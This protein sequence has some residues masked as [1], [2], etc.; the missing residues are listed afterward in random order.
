MLNTPPSDPP[1]RQPRQSSLLGRWLGWTA[2]YAMLVYVGFRFTDGG[3]TGW[4]GE[5]RGLGL[6]LQFLVPAVAAFVIGARFRSW[7]WVLGPI[8]AI[9]LPFAVLMVGA[10]LIEGWANEIVA[11]ILALLFV[12]LIVGAVS[13]L[14][15]LAG[16]WWGTRGDESGGKSQL[17]A[18]GE[19]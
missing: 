19:P 5:D 2:L 6:V 18:Q 1:S 4:I 11:V 13:S 12:P 10:W 16:V 14:A 7:W 9:G 3:L 8:A 15:A 17:G